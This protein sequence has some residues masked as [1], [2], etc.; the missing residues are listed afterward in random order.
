MPK[1]ARKTWKRIAKKDRKNLKLWAEGARDTVLRPHIPAY[2]D[3]L[4]RGWRAER[5]YV[6]EVCN[7]FHAR[8]PWRLQDD[9]EPE[10]PLPEYDPC[11]S[12]ETEELDDEEAEQERLRKETLNARISRWLKYRARR[13]RRPL[14]RNPQKDPWA[15][16][17]CKLTGTA[18]PAK[19]R[20]AYQQYMHESY[21]SVIEP[22][23]RARWNATGADE[24]GG[25][26]TKKGIDANFRATVARELFH[27]LPANEQ[28]ALRQRAKDEATRAKEEYIKH[29]KAGPSKAPEDRQ[30]CID[31]LGVFMSTLLREIYDHTGL[32]SFAVFGG[33]IPN[34][35]GEL[36]NLTV[37]HGR[38]LGAGGCTFPLW[39]KARFGHDVLDFMKEW[40]KG[41]Y[42]KEQCEEAALPT[43]D[44]VLA[45]ATYRI[46]DEED[47]GF[48]D[49][50][51]S[52]PS[53]DESSSESEASSSDDSD[54]EVEADVRGGKKGRKGLR[55][56][57]G[58]KNGK[59]KGKEKEK[60]DEERQRDKGKGKKDKGKDKAAE[61]NGAKRKTKEVNGEDE[62]DNAHAK[63]K[64][65]VEAGV[66]RKCKADELSK[67]TGAKKAKRGDKSGD[68][69]DTARRPKPRPVPKGS[70]ASASEPRNGGEVGGASGSGG[71]S[72]DPPGD[73]APPV[74]P[75]D[76]PNPPPPQDP[77]PEEE[78]RTFK[79]PP[80]PPCPEDA[81]D[82]FR[83]VYPEVTA[84]PVGDCFNHLLI[85]WAGLE[86]TYS[87]VKKAPSGRSSLGTTGR[88]SQVA[89]WIGAGRGLRGGPMREGAGP[90]I[91]S[92][93]KFEE[94]WW[95]WWSA[96]QPA[97][98]VRDGGH[99]GRFS[100]EEYGGKTRE[101]WET[102]RAPGQNGMLSVV[103]ALYWW[104]VKLVK[105][106]DGEEKR[107]W[108]EAHRQQLPD[109][110][111]FVKLA[112]TEY[113][114]RFLISF[115]SAYI[116]ATFALL[117]D[118]QHSDYLLF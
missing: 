91:G 26:R 41:V 60:D 43:P 30:K 106:I 34:H 99:P 5:D 58:K 46:D 98:R 81:G 2:T 40:L 117:Y 17:L 65:T 48:V 45:G 39:M 62:A 86:Q 79:D 77:G 92:V 97:W 95:Q 110:A 94:T 16:L 101:D 33:P 70:G 42:T 105:R 23:V 116:A 37:A 24:D 63:K 89:L 85:A 118:V 112:F 28:D 1:K 108:A 82:W 78:E 49:V 36:R 14:A 3:A 67:D 59:G 53:S 107:T 25:L 73:S 84:E 13:L 8:I 69:E 7:E 90:T 19:A 11:A 113:S 22:V 18:P 93:V 83:A 114:S 52:D 54:S 29:L 96:L 76:D 66:A 12:R 109:N 31:N 80:P 104:G 50:G 27:E 100:R 20:Q 35:G 56:G 51:N 64:K 55:K 4:E 47:L 115:C 88:P 38:S 68:G 57:K 71:L 102:L 10:L 72:N 103:A 111:D 87:W 15:R 44:D 32:V 74:A 6:R 21:E 75:P 61:G 9:E